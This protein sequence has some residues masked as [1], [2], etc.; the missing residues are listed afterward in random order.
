MKRHHMYGAAICVATWTAFAQ[1]LPPVTVD[2]ALVNGALYVSDNAD[3]T[4][5]GTLPG[6]VAAT[7]APNG[8][9]NPNF[10]TYLEISDVVSVNGQ[11]M[12]GTFLN[13]GRLLQ[14]SPSPRPGQAISDSNWFTIGTQGIDFI[15]PDGIRVGT[16]YT[17]GFAIAAPPP[18]SPAGYYAVAAAV[19]GGTG[20]YVGATG[21]CLIANVGARTAS[22]T[23]DPAN[24]RSLGGQPEPAIRHNV[25]Q[26][27]PA[28]RPE[29]EAVY[30]ADFTPVTAAK[31]A[32]KGETL[33]AL[34]T[35]LG[36]T[37]PG[38]DPGQPFLPIAQGAHLVNSPVYVT[39]N[40]ASATVVNA[41]GWPGLVEAYRVD[42]QLPAGTA[43][44][45]AAAQ[46][47]AAWIPGHLINIPVQ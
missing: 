2:A 14:L 43:S 45:Q 12:K 17:S 34:C 16:I 29:I 6:P 25:C 46:L 44:G 8:L 18:G 11:P 15:T 33:I 20:A 3:Y 5:F 24:R 41:L 37:R 31:P 35:G 7:P 9:S 26:V 13:Q 10:A 30:H 39:V 21:Q 28:F 38:V 27:T 22:I 32:R 4:K 19:Q 40:G 23:E 36:P 42:F 1:K 47:T